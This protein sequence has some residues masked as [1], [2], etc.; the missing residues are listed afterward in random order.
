[1][2]EKKLRRRPLDVRDVLRWIDAY[3]E[4]TGR[5]PTRASGDI[6]G[7]F[8][9][10]WLA[11]D[12]ALRSGRRNLPCVGSLIKLLA[13]ERGARPLDQRPDLT[14]DQVL[15]HADAWF[16]RTGTWPT[17]TSG[18]IPDS[19]GDT[20]SAIDAALHQGR[21]TL[22]GK[23]S[24][25]RLLA[26]H[27]GVR[28][29]QNLP[30][31]FEEQ[32]LAWADAWYGRTGQWPNADSGP[33]PEAPGETWM[34]VDTAL[35]AGAR[36]LTAGGSLARLLAEK[37]GA[38]NIQDPIDIPREQLLVW[39]DAHHERTRRW[40]TQ[41]SGPV[42]EAPEISWAA[43]NHALRR[44][45]RTLPGGSSLAELLRI[46]RGVRN[47]QALPDFSRKQIRTWAIAH[48]QRTGH[49]PD[50]SSGPIPEAPGETWRTVDQAFG[51]QTRGLRGGASS[52][53]KFLAEHG[54]KP[55]QRDRP[56]LS[57]KKIVAFADDHH[58]RTGEWP[59]VNSG[60]VLADPRERWDLI[61]NA[62]RLGGRHLTRRT[63]LAQL[64]ARKRGVRN[65]QAL[66]PLSLEQIVRCARLYLERTGAWPTY[67]SG[68][69]PEFPGETWSGWDWALRNA[70]RELTVRSS[71]AKLGRKHLAGL[72]WCE[73][74]NGEQPRQEREG[75]TGQED[76]TP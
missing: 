35:R 52:L 24:L 53:A 32:I 16:R 13:Q 5:W 1:M 46:E 76:A 17:R 73:G 11:V 7:T 38:R 58:E 20:W 72:G 33:V 48:H 14:I 40:P 2:A 29:K 28:N 15:V 71:L 56:P 41:Y 42:Q 31:L 25:A 12:K 10:T 37:R 74:C 45:T 51:R 61:D 54:M 44:G 60:R 65:L 69:I 70:K 68:P 55:H 21:R 49:W 67:K 34:A 36:H 26:E 50:R 4:A 22:P 19:G 62:L 59:H 8:G 63:S 23:S 27:R 9:E 57:L 47:C 43:I 6:P 30:H 3:R 39:I 66:P 75:D 64:L 18:L